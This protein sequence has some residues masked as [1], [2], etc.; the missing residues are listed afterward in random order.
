MQIGFGRGG[1]KACL[2]PLDGSRVALRMREKRIH[3]IFTISVTLKGLHALIEI[4]GGLALAFTST[5]TIVAWI[6]RLSQGELV[7][8]PNDWIARKVM[9][10]GQAFSVER[11]HFYAFYLLSHG[12]IKGALVIGLLREKLWAYP[13]SVVVFGAFIAYQLYRYSFT[14]DFTLILLSIFDLFVIYLTV[15]EYRL[16][17]KHLPTH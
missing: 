1:V 8:D 14:H 11:H 2:T 4:V 15:H 5:A 6:D 12:I 7:E 16:L 10:F 9:E 13:A 3:Q 17:R